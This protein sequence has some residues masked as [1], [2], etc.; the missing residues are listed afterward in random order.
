[1]IKICLDTNTLQ[2]NWLATGEAFTL[3]GELIAKGE[4]QASI[5]EISILEHV[6][7]YEKE[8]PEI[9]AKM[10]SRLGSYAKLFLEE[11]KIPALPPLYDV[12]TFEEK[13]RARLAQLGIT[14]LPVPAVPHAELVARDLSEKKPF[15]ASGKGYRDALI[16]LSFLSVIDG[17]TTKAILVTNNTSDFGSQDKSALHT[18]LIAEITTKNPQCEGL[19]FPAPQKLVDEV[20]KPLLKTLAEEE[21]KTKKILKRIQG[22]KYKAFSLEDVVTEELGNNFDSQEPEGTFYA[23]DEALEEPLYVTMVEDPTEVEATALYKLKSGDYLCEGTAEVTATVEG[24]LDKFE[25]FNQSQLG[26]AFVMNPDHNEH[27]AEVEVP[28]VP[29]R[30]TFSFEFTDGEPDIWKFEVTKVESTHSWPG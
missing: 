5:S 22:G 14:V 8:A 23:G 27:Y 7:H 2:N 30:I 18:E 12:P 25:A 10:K 21:A 17:D 4:C 1:M 9:E 13:F 26:Y 15:A 3:L 16:W 28:N 20:V 6:R 19:W 24:Y 29:A 11:I